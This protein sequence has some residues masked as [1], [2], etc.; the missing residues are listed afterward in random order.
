MKG[1]RA[2][3]EAARNFRAFVAG[4]L[5]D[6][7][8]VAI[9]EA[10]SV[11]VGGVS[12]QGR[13]DAVFERVSGEGQ[14]FLVVDWKSGSAGYAS[15]EDRRSWPILRRSYACT[16]VHGLPAWASIPQR[17]ARWS[18]SWRGRRTTRWN[19]L[20]GCLVAARSCWTRP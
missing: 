15:D 10:F 4:E 12:V 6:Y 20:S 19:R 7:R 13:I 11:E 9:E 14:R 3:R 18:R 16:G 2:A 5:A 17:S 8:A 1:T